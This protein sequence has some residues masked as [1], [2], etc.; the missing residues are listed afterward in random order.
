MN[1]IDS[2]IVIFIA[3]LTFIL[4]FGIFIETLPVET[5]ISPQEP[6]I[7]G[8]L[9]E[10]ED[11]TSKYEVMNILKNCKMPTN[12][13]IEYDSDIMPKRYYIIVDQDKKK[14]LISK[15][16]R[17]ENWTDPIFPGFKRGNY[18]IITVTKKAVEDKNFLET[19]EKNSLQVKKSV[20]CYVLF[21]DGSEDWI[22]GKDYILDK[23]VTILK[24]ELEKN[25]KVLVV[26]FD[27]LEGHK[28]AAQYD[29]P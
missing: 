2:K 21:G 14:D 15:L 10:F 22:E 11:G 7:G 13:S 3:F 5:K 26:T 9:I 23:N 19:L 25:E 20:P 18:Y 17:E 6:E 1:K 27:Y 16:K 4:V 28:S 8:L 29:W 12:Y 24:D